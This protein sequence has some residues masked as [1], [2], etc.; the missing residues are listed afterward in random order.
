MGG[1]TP[2][3]IVFVLLGQVVT[4]TTLSQIRAITGLTSEEE[5][6]GGT[7]EKARLGMNSIPIWTTTR[8]C[9]H[10][11]NKHKKIKYLYCKSMSD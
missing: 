3:C 11:V 6:R 7:A 10:D 1:S 4:E 9:S 2:L 5:M 8:T